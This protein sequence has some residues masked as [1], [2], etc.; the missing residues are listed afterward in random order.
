[1][2]AGFIGYGLIGKKRHEACKL[3]KIDTSFVVDPLL[4]TN[5]SKGFFNS[6]DDIPKKIINE[7][8]HTFISL[9]H[10]LVYPTFLKI[11]A[12]AKNILIEK[13]LGISF[14]E[15]KKIHNL[16]RENN[17]NLAGGFNYRYLKNIKKLKEL[18]DEGFF[19]SI[20]SVE[21]HLSHG[22][23][24]AMEKEW[25]LSK[26]DA[27][28]GVVIDPGVHLIDLCFYLFNK[29]LSLEY[30]SLSTKFWETDVE[31][32]CLLLLSGGGTDFC[33]SVNLFD[34]KNLFE[35]KI[36]GNEGTAK[37]RGR[38]GNYGDLEIE[39]CKK[40]FWQSGDSVE[41]LNFSSNDDSFENE[42]YDFLYNFN[43]KDLSKSD[44]S[45]RVM[46]IVSDIYEKD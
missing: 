11:M 40:W 33:L 19:G 14:E 30:K 16:A 38:G 3:N 13:P 8:S 5:L 43:N 42:T 29:D 10:N 7:T 27:G 20:L 17:I 41:V 39:Y 45:L 34:W 9:P 22:G 32:R 44:D 36:Y 28:G 12:N 1:M 24:P 35:I 2:K 23:R 46:K 37:L 25:K 26:K 31:D 15:A 4:E 21:M 18:L 6:V